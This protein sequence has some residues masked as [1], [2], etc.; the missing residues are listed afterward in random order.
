M[1]SPK[2][3]FFYT[4]LRTKVFKNLLDAGEVIYTG[5]VE[6]L[7]ESCTSCIASF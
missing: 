6:K 1:K 2:D 5:S 4:G 3:I 7:R